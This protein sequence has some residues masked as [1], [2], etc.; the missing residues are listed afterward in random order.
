M[1]RMPSDPRLFLMDWLINSLFL[2]GLCLPVYF[3]FRQA[4]RGLLGGAL[5]FW[6]CITA[7]LVVSVEYGVD[8]DLAPG[9]YLLGGWLIGLVYCV[10]AIAVVSVWRSWRPNPYGYCR[11]CGRCMKADLPHCPVGHSPVDLSRGFEVKMKSAG[12]PQGEAHE[13]E[14]R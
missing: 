1:I 9:F 3:V 13:S 4:T 8:T 11:K 12:S 14:A 2:C 10:P 7:A 6:V 5:S